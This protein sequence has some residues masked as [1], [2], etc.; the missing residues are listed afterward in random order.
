[1]TNGSISVQTPQLDNVCKGILSKMLQEGWDKK[2]VLYT[3]D[4]T[5]VSEPEFSYLMRNGAVFIGGV[6][7]GILKSYA[8]GQQGADAGKIAFTLKFDLA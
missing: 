3:V 7:Q 6:P 5:Q 2:N 1:M 4:Q 8:V